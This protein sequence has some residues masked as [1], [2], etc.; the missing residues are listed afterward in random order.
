M[1]RIDTIIIVNAGAPCYSVAYTALRGNHYGER[2]LNFLHFYYS[3]SLFFFNNA[4][5][6]AIVY[7]LNAAQ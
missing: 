5:I 3:I 7:V 1:M 6:V 4:T 2:K